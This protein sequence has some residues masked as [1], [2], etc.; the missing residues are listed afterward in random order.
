M[1][2]YPWTHNLSQ[3]TNLVKPL[4]PAIGI[5]EDRIADLTPFAVHLRYDVEFEPSLSAARE[6]LVTAEEVNQLVE[7]SLR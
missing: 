1:M 6:A 3:L 5:L 7:E 2:E 4:L